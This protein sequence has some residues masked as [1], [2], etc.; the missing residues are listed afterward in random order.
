MSPLHSQTSVQQRGQQRWWVRKGSHDTRQNQYKTQ[1]CVRGPGTIVPRVRRS[2]IPGC[3]FAVP[4]RPVN[5]TEPRDGVVTAASQRHRPADPAW[6]CQLNE[7]EGSTGQSKNTS[8]IYSEI[9]NKTCLNSPPPPPPPPRNK[10]ATISQM[11]FSNEFTWMKSF[12]LSFNF[13]WCLFLRAQLTNK[14]ALVDNKS[15]LVQATDWHRVGDKPLPDTVHC[16][17]EGVGMSWVDED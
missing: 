5:A 17:I 14:L 15:M 7:G 9:Y 1:H 13:Y 16:R 3:S 4:R 11:T 8:M 12:I 2:R 10:K 6:A